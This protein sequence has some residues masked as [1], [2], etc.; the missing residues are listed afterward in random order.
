MQRIT[1]KTLNIY[2]I[3]MKHKAYLSMN[4]IRKILFT[5]NIIL[6]CEQKKMSNDHQMN[7][8]KNLYA[9]I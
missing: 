9:N 8:Y 1:W 3:F 4:Y 2:K 5:Y 6:G 7:V